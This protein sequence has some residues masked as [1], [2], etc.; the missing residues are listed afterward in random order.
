MKS[1]KI[2][3]IIE[4]LKE[5]FNNLSVKSEYDSSDDSYIIYVNDLSTYLDDSFQDYITD[6]ITEEFISNRI[7]NF[8]FLYSDS[9]FEAEEVELIAKNM[10][11]TYE[12]EDNFITIL[13]SITSGYVN[14]KDVSKKLQIESIFNASHEILLNV[15]NI[16]TVTSNNIS[17][18]QKLLK[19]TKR[20]EAKNSYLWNDLSANSIPMSITQ[21]NKTSNLLI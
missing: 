11:V 10:F 19:K 8:S 16:L 4:R 13:E 18:E 14:F 2:E 17:H 15:C 6:I 5:R 3:G 9:I 12:Y 21:T 7:P 20:L 1:K